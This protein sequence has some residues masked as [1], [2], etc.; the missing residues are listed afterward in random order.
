VTPCNDPRSPPSFNVIPRADFWDSFEDT[1]NEAEFET[2]IK[3]IEFWKGDFLQQ[4]DTPPSEVMQQ[5]RYGSMTHGLAVV[6]GNKL[7]NCVNTA[8]D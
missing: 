6:L 4:L 1:L 5:P 3:E 2:L 7:V 8:T